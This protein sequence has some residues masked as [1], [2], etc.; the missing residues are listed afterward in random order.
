M[1]RKFR[2]VVRKGYWKKNEKKSTTNH[3][4]VTKDAALQTESIT[5]DTNATEGHTSESREHLSLEDEFIQ[6]ESCPTAPS[7]GM[8]AQAYTNETEEHTTV[9]IEHSSLADELVQCPMASVPTIDMAVQA[10]ANE[11]E[12]HTTE[13]IEHTSFAVRLVQS[14]S[15]PTIPNFD[16][17]VQAYENLADNDYIMYEGNRDEK[18]LPLVTKHK[19]IFKDAK[20][21]YKH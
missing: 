18:F 4:L 2:R 11:T 6:S 7:I 1:P 21:T 8:A 19:G 13:P 17:A 3:P 20:G 10:C 15:R 16:M 12:E 14:Q 5:P 9:S